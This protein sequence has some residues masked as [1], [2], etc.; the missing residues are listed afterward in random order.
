MV[1]G[2]MVGM[3]L[4]LALGQQN[5]QVLVLEQAPAK[6]APDDANA[7][8]IALSYAS[9]CIYQQ[10]GVWDQLK[11]NLAQHGFMVKMSNSPL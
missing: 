4:A 2:G 11:V 9:V 6:A 3:S 5:Y 8:T 10:L 7:R 1:G